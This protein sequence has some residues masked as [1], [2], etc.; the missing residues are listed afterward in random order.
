MNYASALAL[1]WA[2]LLATGPA[3]RATVRLPALVGSHMVLQRNRPVPVWGWAAPGEAV[4]VRLN[5]HTY[6]ATAPDASGRWQATLPAMP[7]GGPYTLLV[8]GTNTL[9]LTDVLVGDVWLAAGQSNM[10]FKVRDRNPGGYQP[11]RDADQEIA[12]ANWP[13]LRLL[14]VAQTAAYR[15]QAE[16]ASYGGWQVCS[17]AT[18]PDFSAVAYF[19]ARDL[20]Q[21][22]QVPIGVVVSSW[23]GTP[24]EAWTSAEGLRS[25][26]EFAA[27]VADLQRRPHPLADDERAYQTQQAQ[28]LAHLRDYDQGY[29]PGQLPWSAAATD[30]RAWPTMPVPGNWERLPALASY[31]GPMWFRQDIDLPATLTGQPLTLNL[32]AI[33]DADSTWVDGVLVGHGAGWD[34]P[35]HYAV[36]AALTQ[37]GRHVLTVR[38]LD[39]GGNGGFNGQPADFSLSGNGAALP[40]AGTWQ[41]QPGLT[42]AHQLLPPYPG[43][44]QMAPTTLFN[45]MVNPLVPL[46]LKGV[47]WYQGETNVG[48]ATQYRTLFAALIAD[49]RQHWGTE[50]PFVFVQL[51]GWKAVQ[52]QPGAS[53]LAELR[54]AQAAALRLPRTGMATAIDVGDTADIHPHDKQTVGH[55][56][57]LAARRVA[58]GETDLISSGPTLAAHTATGST[59]RLSFAHVGG[60]LV[61]QG[62]GPLRGFALAGADRQF[63]W[64]TAKLAGNAVLLS[65]PQ[66]PAPVAVRYDWAS[67]STGNLYN[68][69]GLPAPPFRTDSWPGTEAAK[70]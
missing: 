18:V 3:A 9:T 57:A 36:P 35:R 23:G 15:P 25:L 54:E 11:V 8:Q 42:A 58:Y 52:L 65:C 7:A 50:L 34:V 13:R 17:P 14:T 20:L 69:E 21:R 31:D 41:Y 59:V 28:L 30:A 60:G 5:G 44:A 55:R 39:T 47:I 16:V 29:A 63:H 38:V 26:P 10:Q 27:P 61:A 56:L 46:A 68:Q 51:A 33:D 37:P 24:A 22:Y 66:V 49:W 1:V 62:G 43:G 32:G 45:G 6:P 12:A 64:A 40:L 4:V 2:G 67:H 48:R 19:F 53:A 70:P